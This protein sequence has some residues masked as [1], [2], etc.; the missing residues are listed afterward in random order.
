MVIAIFGESCTGKSTLARAL[1]ERLGGEVYTGK[2]YLRK[3]G[4]FD[5]EAHDYHYISGETDLGAL[6]GQIET[7]R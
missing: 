6:C 2:D 7:K 3:H 5:N 1:K 4:C